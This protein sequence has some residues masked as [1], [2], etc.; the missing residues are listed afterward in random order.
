MPMFDIEDS[1]NVSLDR[2]KTSKDKLAKIKNVDGFSATDNE[3]AVVQEKKDDEI[4][5]LKPNF[6][7]F[8][9]NLRALWRK[10]TKIKQ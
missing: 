2:N 9:I 4:L 8:G 1:S 7:G 3:A 5:E 10:F 6:I